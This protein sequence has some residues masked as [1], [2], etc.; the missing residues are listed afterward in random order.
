MEY[1]KVTVLISGDPRDQMY[2]VSIVEESFFSLIGSGFLS[3]LTPT[4]LFHLEIFYVPKIW[5]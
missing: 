5:K 1:E 2:G 4:P 3:T